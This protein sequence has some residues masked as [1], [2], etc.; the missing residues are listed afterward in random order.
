MFW[1]LVCGTVDS[2]V[3]VPLTKKCCK[4]FLKINEELS[5]V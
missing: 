4:I 5:S 1:K 3:A 2:S